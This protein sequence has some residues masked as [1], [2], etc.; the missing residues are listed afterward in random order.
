M[1]IQTRGAP[2]GICNICGE[3][4]QLTDDHIPPRGVS[5]LAAVEM[6]H[7]HDL[8]A[9]GSAPRQSARFSQ[10]GFKFRTLCKKCNNSLLGA[11]YDPVLAALAADVR[12]FLKSPLT[13]PPV[14]NFQTEPNKLVRCVVGHLLAHGLD[15][16][17][18]GS[19]ID[20]LTD[21]FL[22][23][24]ALFPDFIRLYY[25]VYPYKD[26][27]VVKGAG[28]FP[29]FGQSHAVFLL[30]KFFPLSFF[31][32]IDE[33]R[34]WQVPHRRLDNLL[35]TDI[36]R[37]AVLPVNFFGLPPQRWPEAPAEAGMVLYGDGATAA[38]PR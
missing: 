19:A 3:H 4:G 14:G 37:R 30:M 32:V 38:I 31:F 6:L 1:K 8:L 22:D 29:Y 15:E 27:V 2:I 33:P 24:E 35:T 23:K 28:L 26:Q 17:R 10:N 13:L 16:H 36:A 20:A 12:A 21:Y 9:V 25:W 5:Q 7:I 34:E 18:S 11:T